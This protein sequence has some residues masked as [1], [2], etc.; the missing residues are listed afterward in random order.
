MEGACRG[1]C[2]GTGPGTRSRSLRRNV[3]ATSL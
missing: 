1:S 3:P 2:A